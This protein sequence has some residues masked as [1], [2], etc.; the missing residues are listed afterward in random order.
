MKDHD[1]EETGLA[2]IAGIVEDRDMAISPKGWNT[3]TGEELVTQKLQTT[4]QTIH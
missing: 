1:K 4:R 3:S 2:E